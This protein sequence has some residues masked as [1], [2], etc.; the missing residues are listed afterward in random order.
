MTRLQLTAALIFAGVSATTLAIAEDDN[1]SR[2]VTVAMF[3]DWPYS[4]FLLDNGGLLVNSVNTDKRVD[5]VFHVG[6]LHS[7]SM[8]CTSA[9][10]LPPI[11]KS[12]PGWNQ[13]VFFQFQQFNAPVIYTPG[14]NEWSDCQKT[15]QFASGAPLN[16][17]ASVRSLFFARPGRTLGLADKQ[18]WSQAK[19]FDPDFPADAQF[20]ENVMWQDR[21]VLFATFNIPG[22]SNNDNFDSAPWANGFGNEAAQ[23]QEEAQRNA[24]DIRWLE[25]TFA[26]AEHAPRAKAVVIAVQADMWDPAALP[27][28]AGAGLDHYTAFVKRLADLAVHFGGP[29]LLVNGDTHLYFSDKPLANPASATGVIHH[30]QAVPNLTRIVVQGSTSAPS[31]WLRLTI[32]TRKFQPFSWTNVPYCQ[33]PDAAVPSC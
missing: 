13:S 8:P 33:H 31:E 12:N 21:R 11:L 3:G 26:T 23:R 15:K 4:Q 5:W 1:S 6:D 28:A 9:G 27:S 16:E 25:T 24:A 7:G 29:V 10:I 30:T 18:V 32:D 14:D 20:V 22:G 2:P 17:L 19:Y